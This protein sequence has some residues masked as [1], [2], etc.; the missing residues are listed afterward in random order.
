MDAAIAIEE[1]AAH[2]A[3]G[4]R[5]PRRGRPG[6]PGRPEG[7]PVPG[8]RAVRRRDGRAARHRV[9]PAAPPAAH[10]RRH[11]R[12]AR[13]GRR[14]AARHGAGAVR[15]VPAEPARGR[16]PG[17]HRPAHHQL[18]GGPGD[19]PGRGVGRGGRRPR[20][21]RRRAGMAAGRRRRGR[22]PGRGGD[23]LPAAADHR[24]GA[25]HL[26]AEPA[27]QL[28]DRVPGHPGRAVDR[29]GPGLRGPAR[30]APAGPAPVTG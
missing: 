12:R 11:P 21:A 14:R 27:V 17:H 10:R 26:P 22:V 5:P 18:P 13:P 9:H 7:R 30:A 6:R 23:R 19:R 15:Q 4:A 2:A 20:A 3:G 1:A 25:G 16:R 8:H 29:A 24:R 28:P